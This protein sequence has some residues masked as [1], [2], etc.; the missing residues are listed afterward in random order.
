MRSRVLKE[1]AEDLRDHVA[2]M[3]LIVET[4]TNIELDDEECQFCEIHPS[5]IGTPMEPGDKLYKIG[6]DSHL[7]MLKGGNVKIT[8]NSVYNEY[9]IVEISRE[10]A[11]MLAKMLI[12]ASIELK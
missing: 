9:K 6:P 4:L 3:E 5:D 10:D 7:E 1:S 11:K 8:L 12:L 2:D